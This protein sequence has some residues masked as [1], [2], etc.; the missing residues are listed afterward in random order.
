MTEKK[1]IKKEADFTVNSSV[2]LDAEET[3]P[4]MSMHSNVISRMC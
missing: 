1:Y 3:T 4:G 2:S